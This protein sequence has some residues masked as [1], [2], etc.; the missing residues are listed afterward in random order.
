MTHVA[1]P[2]RIGVIGGGLTGLAAAHRVG[3][4]S[5]ERRLSVEVTLLEAGPR[6]GGLVG[7]VE[8]AGYLIDTGADSFITNKP[9]ALELCRRLGLDHRLQATEPRYRGALV[10]RR[11]RPRPVPEGFQ[12]LSPTALGP[13]LASPVLSPWG[14]L[15][16]ACEYFVPA[17]RDETDESL[18]SF[19]RRRF[20]REVLDR[21]V[22]P[23]VA[24]IYTSDP[25]RLSL[26]ATLPRFLD[27]ER[28][29]GSLLRAAW[30]TSASSNSHVAEDRTS[31]GARYGLFAGLQGG[32]QELVDALVRR[33]RE[34]TTILQ[35]AEV[36]AV[37]PRRTAPASLEY[38][39]KLRAG[40]D[41]V[42][43]AVLIALPTAKAA[44]VLETCD[45]ALAAA[46]RGI[47][48]ASSVIV[49]SGHALA[50]IEH[51]LNAFGLVIPHSERRRIIAVS[52][53]SRK[54]PNRAPAGRVLLRTFV[55]GALQPELCELSDADLRQ[56][57]RDELRDTLGV[58]GVPDFMDVFRYP[59]SMPQYYVG[60]LQR[61]ADIE[62]LAAQHPRLAL[63]GNAYRGVGVPDAIHSGEC[64]AER[65]LSEST[66]ATIPV[67][68]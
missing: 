13:V 57:V 64:A 18:A 49:V 38:C 16:L 68:G 5:R 46:L 67:E 43:D 55:G 2:V 29:Y 8:Q 11:G 27:M 22:Q 41:V 53:S 63:A 21:L 12:L 62:R 39:L 3:E 42:V 59:H 54:F 47:E 4:L 58:G 28:Q 44:A 26:A 17:R 6:L 45:T 66:S 37:I 40:S 25:E 65:I 51:P 19:V 33:V 23:L 14:K 35:P 56:L 10:L 50:E 1:Q 7:T 60:H 36:A 24:G 48:Y 32:M 15:R 34:W 9:G 61:V 30:R 31:S 20:G 52:F